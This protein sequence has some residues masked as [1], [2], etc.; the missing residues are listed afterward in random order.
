MLAEMAAAMKTEGADYD[1]PLN[2]T[3]AGVTCNAWSRE[4]SSR[5]RFCH[6]SEEAH[7]CFIATRLFLAEALKEDICFIECVAGYEVVKKVLV[8]LQKT[9]HCLYWPD[10]PMAR[11]EPLTRPRCSAAAINRKSYVFIDGEDDQWR[12]GFADMHQRSMQLTGAAYIMADPEERASEMQRLAT[13]QGNYVDIESI[14]ALTTD[15]V[16][17]SCFPTGC[18]NRYQ[19]YLAQKSLKCSLGGD[20]LFDLDHN[21]KMER[22]GTHWPAMLT[23]G[24]ICC[25]TTSGQVVATSTEHLS[26][27]GWHLHTS[28]AGNNPISPLSQFFLQ[29]SPAERKVLA[30]RGVHLSS[31][32]KWMYFV[33]S[34]CV[35]VQDCKL[36]RC[37]SSFDADSDSEAE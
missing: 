35:R 12:Q 18:L 26:A 21:A 24:T 7:N 30:G 36:E 22:G 3:F 1:R 14:K 19:D 8:P 11:G 23:H 20:Y 13:G 10:N 28:T 31:L 5:T 27:L 15:E 34:K 17:Y 25:S 2:V 37:L 4:N 9:H 29:R 32:S 16:I 6:P 33:L